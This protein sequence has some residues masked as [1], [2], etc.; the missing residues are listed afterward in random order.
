M[1]QIALNET[2][3]RLFK[4]KKYC[5]PGKEKE[6]HFFEQNLPI[7]TERDEMVDTPQ[8]FAPYIITELGDIVSP[9]GDETKKV[10]VTMYICAYDTGLYRQGYRDVVNIINDIM[11]HFR[12]V[13]RFGR[14]CTVKGDIKGVLSEDDYAPYY[15]GAVKMTCTVPNADPATD[16][17]IE[18]MV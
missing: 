9:E 14:A 10:D 7:D 17:E 12:T 13:P 4:G 6:L 1:M 15:F 8:A 5:G 3:S 16:P 11:N 18:E 2:L